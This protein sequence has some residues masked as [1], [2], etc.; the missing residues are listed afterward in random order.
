GLDFAGR[1]RGRAGHLAQVHRITRIRGIGHVG[2]SGVRRI[3]TDGGDRRA[4]SDGQPV[5]VDHRVASGHTVQ[6]EVAIQRH[7]HLASIVNT[8]LGDVDVAV[9]AKSHRA[10]GADVVAVAIGVGHVPA[11]GCRRVY[12]I[13]GTVDISVGG[14]VHVETGRDSTGVAVIGARSTQCRGHAVT[15]TVERAAYRVQLRTVDGIRTVRTDSTSGHVLDLALEITAT[16]GDNA[17]I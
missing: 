7:R 15:E 6:V 10:V 16:D 4:A 12:C 11:C 17:M 5:G 9:T 13:Q 3:D 1:G 14:S 2:H 8:R